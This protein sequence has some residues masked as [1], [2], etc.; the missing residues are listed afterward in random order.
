MPLCYAVSFLVL[1]WMLTS[2]LVPRLRVLF[3]PGWWLSVQMG[4]WHFGKV[5]MDTGWYYTHSVIC[6]FRIVQQPAGSAVTAQPF[7]L[8][9]LMQCCN[10]MLECSII[11]FAFYFWLLC[12]CIIVDVWSVCEGVFWA[13]W[14][15]LDVIFIGVKHIESAWQQRNGQCK[16]T[17]LLLLQVP[18]TSFRIVCPV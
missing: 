10:V 5:S 11:F 1:G 6:V 9:F 3:M 4:S 2:A 16:C 15:Y 13:F 7:C 17:L 14:I 12:F 18:V 8:M